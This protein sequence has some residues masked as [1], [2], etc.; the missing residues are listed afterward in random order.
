[1]AAVAAALTAQ[2]WAQESAG[3]T[4]AEQKQALQQ[5][6]D[7][8]YGWLLLIVAQ[9][10]LGIATILTNKAADIATLH[11]MVGAL[12][13]VAGAL[14]CVVA[15]ARSPGVLKQLGSAPAPGAAAD[16][17]S[18]AAS[19]SARAVTAVSSFISPLRGGP[20]GAGMNH[21]PGVGWQ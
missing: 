9:V 20:L 7:T 17:S 18:A 5:V 14:W 13:L 3:P 2:A 11:V 1:M 8:G 16:A 15:F 10:G 12:S 21:P 6:K 19:A 4:A